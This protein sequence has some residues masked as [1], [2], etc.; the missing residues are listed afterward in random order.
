MSLRLTDDKSTLVQVMAWCRQATIHYLIQCWPRS[1]ASLGPNE[2]RK[3]HSGIRQS[4]NCHISTMGFL[5]MVRRHL[6]IESGPWLQ[7]V[8]WVEI[9][10]ECQWY[11][12]GLVKDCSSSSALTVGIM[13]SCTKLTI[14]FPEHKCETAPDYPLSMQVSDSWA[15]KRESCGNYFSSKC[16]PRNQW[17]VWKHRENQRQGDVRGEGRW[18]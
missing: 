14:L 18:Q 3:S 7:C 9:F 12:I 15:R 1:M 16:P 10:V 6:Y 17:S 4:H 13:Q 8:E 11:C 5:I 2:L